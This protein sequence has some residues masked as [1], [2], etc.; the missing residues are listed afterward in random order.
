M[1]PAGFQAPTAA[2]MRQGMGKLVSGVCVVASRSH[3]GQACGMTVGSTTSI[4]LDP[5]IVMVSLTRGTRTANAVGRHGRF[6]VSVLSARQ[7]VLARRFATPGGARFGDVPCDIGDAGLPMLRDVLAQLQCRLYECHDIGDHAVCY[8]LVTSLRWRDGT[9]LAF[10]GGRFG[11][12]DDL[13]HD[14]MPW[15]I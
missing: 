5:P 11:R 9:G 1:L 4:S 10:V 8:G 6:T 13:G 14:Q 7:E 2:A 12:F 15:L 3:D